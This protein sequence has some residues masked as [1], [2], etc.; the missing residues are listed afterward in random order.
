MNFDTCFSKP[1]SLAVESLGH[2][3]LM[4]GQRARLSPLVLQDSPRY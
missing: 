3:Q 1:K 2:L 4:A